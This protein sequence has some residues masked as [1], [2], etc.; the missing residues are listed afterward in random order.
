MIEVS[1]MMDVIVDGQSQR[2]AATW[3]ITDKEHRRLMDVGM[4]VPRAL[5][6]P[7]LYCGEIEMQLLN[8]ETHIFR[9]H[10]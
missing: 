5:L 6:R 9:A 7:V 2:R 8:G 3:E 4:R 1:L 10:N